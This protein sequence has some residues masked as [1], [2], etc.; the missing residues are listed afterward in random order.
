MN[1]EE[2]GQIKE[3]FW[4]RVQK[5]IGLVPHRV[6]AL[7]DMFDLSASQVIAE[8]SVEWP[9]LIE[10]D[11]RKSGVEIFDDAVSRGLA[12]SKYDVFGRQQNDLATFSLHAAEEVSINNV[13]KLIQ[14]YGI[15]Q[16]IEGSPVL[17]RRCQE[18][19]TDQV[20]PIADDS[21]KML[22]EKLANY[23]RQHE[24]CGV[25]PDYFVDL[26][27]LTIS[28]T[29]D[30]ATVRVTCAVCKKTR[31]MCKRS[32]GNWVTNNYYQHVRTHLRG[33]VRRREEELASLSSEEDTDSDG[34]GAHGDRAVG[35]GS[36][37]VEEADVG[38]GSSVA[39]RNDSVDEAAVGDGSGGA[40]R[41]GSNEEAANDGDSSEA[42]IVDGETVVSSGD[43]GP[44]E[45]GNDGT[46]PVSAG[47]DGA[48]GS[49]VC[50]PSRKS[51]A[52][53]IS[54]YQYAGEGSSR[55]HHHLR[56]G[57]F[58]RSDNKTSGN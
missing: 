36:G 19:G 32:G 53:L 42:A 25:D 14:K 20:N 4:K 50:Q 10:D 41:S 30:Q 15:R 29:G 3:R 18:I 1:A 55:H 27:V 44:A 38:G 57:R 46:A 34:D 21:K 24:E 2:R 13:G 52:D 11:I 45:S 9:K 56:G 7:L 58:L 23:Y 33:V 47:G 22:L 37:S 48:A 17:A 8:A 54:Q 16:F 49:G 6:M 28:N 5:V 12:R 35:G 43:G 40:S 31:P 26:P 39:S 51:V